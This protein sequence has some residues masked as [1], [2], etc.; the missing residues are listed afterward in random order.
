MRLVPENSS[1]SVSSARRRRSWRW[2][3]VQSP[4][5]K[6]KSWAPEAFEDM[7]VSLVD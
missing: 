6:S 4:T 3:I 5:K 2:W 7:A 1:H